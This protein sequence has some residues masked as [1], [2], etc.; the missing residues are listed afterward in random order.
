MKSQRYSKF[1]LCASALL[2]LQL[3]FCVSAPPNPYDL[4]N[5]KIYL[6]LVSSNGQI[7]ADSLA[8]SVGN[9]IKVGITSNFPNYVDSIGL[10]FYTSDGNVEIDTVLKN[11]FLLKNNDTLWYKTSFATKDKRILVATVFA[12]GFK[13]PTRAYFNILDKPLNSVPHSWPHLE[14]NGTKSITAAQICSLSVSAL[15]SNS[16]QLHSFYVK[17]DT[18]SFTQFTPPFKW[19]PPTGFLG[20]HQVLFKVTDTD[21][22]AYFDTQAV[23]ITVTALIDT[24]PKLPHWNKDSVNLNGVEGSSISLTLFDISTGDSL[25]FILM[26]GLPAKDT[27]INA[28]Y[29]YTFAAFDTNN[30]YPKIIVKDKK[31]NADTMMIHLWASIPSIVDTI[32]PRITKI[33]GPAT[34]T[35]TANPND[36][37]VYAIT[38]QSGI[39]TVSWTLNS[40]ASTVLLPDANN[41]YTTK[42]VLISY[43]SNKIIITASDKSSAHNKSSDTTILDYNVPPKANDQN[44]STKKNTALPFTLTADPIDGDALSG[45]TIVTPPANGDLSG[46]SPALIYTPKTG[47]L[48]ADSLSFTVMDG[49]NTSNAGKIKI[50]VSDVLVAPIAGKTIADIVVNKGQPASFVATVNADANPSPVFSWFK[51]GGAVALSANQTYTISQTNYSDQGRYRYFVSNSQGKDTSN[52]ITLTV[53]DVTKPVI[54][55]K[56]ANPQQILVGGTYTELGDSAYDDKDGIITSRVII[57]ASKVKPAQIGSY[58]VTY[59]VKDSAGNSADTMTRLVQI[60]GNA[61]TITKSSGNKE[62]CVNVAAIFSVSA[63]GSQPIKYQWMKGTAAAPGTSSDSTY[64]ITPLSAADAGSFYCVVSNGISPDAQSQNMTLTVDSPPAISGIAANPSTMPVCQGTQ[65]IFTVTATGMAPLTYSWKKNGTAISNGPNA[66][67]YTITAVAASDSGQYSCTVSNGCTSIAN[68]SSI[69]LSIGISASVVTQPVDDTLN[70]PG[71][72]A[73]FKITA[74]GNNLQYQWLKNGSIVNGANS[75]TISVQNGTY[76]DKYKCRVFNACMA[77]TSQE[78]TLKIAYRISTLKT[79]TGSGIINPDSA[80]VVQGSNKVLLFSPNQGSLITQLLI[81]NIPISVASACTLKNVTTEHIVSV[82]F[83]AIPKLMKMISSKG[84]TFKMG[85]DTMEI[86]APAHNI[87]FTNNFYMDSV[88]VTQGDYQALMSV[89]PSSQTG[90]S[91]LPVETVTWF[92]AV[93][94]C[95]VRSKQYG[96]DTVYSYVSI[97]GTPGHG[98]TNLDGINIDY[99][100]TGFRLPT[101]AEWEFT[102]RA[103]TT[104]DYYWGSLIDGNY[105]W[106][107]ANSGFTTHDVATKLPNAWG[108]YDMSGNVYEWCNDWD[109]NYSGIDQ[110]NPLGSSTGFMRIRRGGSLYDGPIYMRSAYRNSY[111]PFQS[112]NDFGFRCVISLL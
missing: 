63:T 70:L 54:V 12:E 13:N 51:E 87:I 52:W 77:D 80:Y 49:K 53:K 72:S 57:D 75:A 99:S 60:F 2:T 42:A 28:V 90:D 86:A 34:N 40:G 88:E 76:G 69:Q 105:C 98:T 37:L 81:D 78:A 108:M 20:D 21:S 16:A 31:G 102:C 84:K 103:G 22:P 3:L 104:S 1:F 30:Y 17:Q 15:D 35:R 43:H 50:N 8:D 65:V 18:G 96:L 59:A 45:W 97:T 32:G 55:L 107:D 74:V 19:A 58:V 7:S 47:F 11:L 9:L 56:G 100:K 109:G 95:N 106:Y 44:L 46:T 38:D 89:N 66:A 73:M 101:E 25:S 39:D 24:Q 26:P 67:T 94:Y 33:S 111:Y 62:T 41:Q 6:T 112:N 71:G 4:S 27:I 48:G 79:G 36:T 61:P 23:T 14:I 68:S 29:S 64:T 83:V 92:D 85:C 82:K 93:L 5:T 10:M 91:K 110:T